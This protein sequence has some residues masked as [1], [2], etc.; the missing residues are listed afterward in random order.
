M[1]ETEITVQVFETLPEIQEKLKSQ[2]FEIVE[3]YQL[4]DY[5]FS[6]Y[7]LSKIK[8]MSYAQLIK[9]SFLVRKIVDDKPH[10]K[11]CFKDKTL[12]KQGNVILEEKIVSNI[13][14]VENAVKIFEKANLTKW[15]FC[16]NNTF[17]YK[18]DTICFALQIIDNLG[19]FIEY[20]EDETMNNLDTQE[21]RNLMKTNL[22]NLGLNLGNDYSCKKVFMLLH[23]TKE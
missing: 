4:I 16:F 19:I 13:T 15:C 5:Y 18:K 7:S 9:N 21:K 10:F 6:K 12:D 23:N 1:K 8:S 17:V 11:L 14:E 20:E 3:N 2:N 22:Q